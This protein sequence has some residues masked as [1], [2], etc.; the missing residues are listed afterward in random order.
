MNIQN[1]KALKEGKVKRCKKSGSLKFS[2]EASYSLARRTL[3]GQY[4]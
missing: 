2:L 3:S 4:E 1:S